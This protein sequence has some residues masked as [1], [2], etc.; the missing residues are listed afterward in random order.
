MLIVNTA[1]KCGFTPQFKG[2]EWLNRTYKDK[3][4]QVLGFPCNQFAKQ[5][6]GDNIAI[7]GFC[8]KNYGVSFPIF[9]KVN[10][11]GS[12]AHPLYKH[13]KAEARGLFWSKRVKW[14]FTKFLVDQEGNVLRRYAPATKPRKLVD[15]I[16]KALRIA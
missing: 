11:N 3:G 4:L 15:D 5:D 9:S 10:V 12:K 13:L 8:Q 2:L 14:N 6:P 1:S 7:A 16:E